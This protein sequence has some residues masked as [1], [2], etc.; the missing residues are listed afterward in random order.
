[1]EKTSDGCREQSRDVAVPEVL[2]ALAALRYPITE[3]RRALV[4]LIV[5]NG[6]RF[7]ADDLLREVRDEGVKV[8]RATVFRTIELLVRLGYVGKV[9]DG[10]RW[11][12]T[13]CT[14]GHHH[15]LT[16]STCGQVV[17]FTDCPASDLMGELES[18]TG[19]RIEH[20]RLEITG[21][22]PTCLWK[23]KGKGPG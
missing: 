17:D 15:H 18:R 3:Q 13:R 12:Y 14:P 16:C 5:S 11:A 19:F 1:M 10:E 21:V 7:T 4:S 23:S 20:H 2:S 22:C 9:H 8:G 6:K